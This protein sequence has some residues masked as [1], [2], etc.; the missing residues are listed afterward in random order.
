MKILVFGRGMPNEEYPQEGCFEWDQVQCLK[1]AKHEVIYM[2][3][4]ARYRRKGHKWGINET[5]IEGVPV[6]SIYWGTLSYLYRLKAYC[7]GDFLLN[8]LALKLFKYIINNNKD[9]D[10]VHSHYLG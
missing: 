5:V 3:L 9:I 8:Q 10:I 6:Y 2:Y 4:D 1:K 7:L